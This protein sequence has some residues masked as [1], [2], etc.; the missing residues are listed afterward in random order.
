MLSSR[1][2]EEARPRLVAAGATVAL[3]L[4]IVL[5]PNGG[6]VEATGIFGSLRTSADVGVVISHRG[7]LE[8]APEN[9]IPAF[10]QAIARGSVLETD[11]QLT[12][13]NVPV[14]M[15]DWT[16]DRTTTGSGPVWEHT[17][18]EL[19]RLDAG[20][21]YSSDFAG[22][23]VPTLEELLDLMQPHGTWAMLELKGSWTVE[24]C[25]LVTDLIE[26]YG[27]ANRV[28]LASFDLVTLQALSVAA[29]DIPRLL[30]AREVNGD[31]AVLAKLSGAVGIVTSDRFISSRPDVV[32]R[33]QKAGL[34]VMVYTVNTETAWERAVKLG[35]D[36][37][38]TD[39]PNEFGSWV[40]S[41][42][43]SS[44]KY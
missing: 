18:E 29:N 36:G 27:V 11:I 20:S 14:L 1:V 22:V 30:I 19:S 23:R 28:I 6:S 24:Q 38:I 8:S 4:V 10:E 7:G 43:A 21:W 3:V 34:G 44:A 40:E 2:P 41:A 42:T 39:R 32:G 12:A 25:E 15:H 17:Y 9:T 35:L 33:I 13:D 5:S 26:S 31:P 37:I 16:I